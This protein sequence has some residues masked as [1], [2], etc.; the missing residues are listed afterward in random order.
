MYTPRHTRPIH[1][2]TPKQPTALEAAIN[3]L[4]NGNIK[5]G[6]DWFNRTSPLGKLVGIGLAIFAAKTI[7]DH[8]K[9]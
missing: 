4:P 8:Y 1:T 9:K 7:I 3:D 2:S 5:A 6:L